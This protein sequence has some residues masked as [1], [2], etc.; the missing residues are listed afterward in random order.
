MPPVSTTVLDSY[1][2]ANNNT[3]LDGT[4]ISYAAA[5][6]TS[7]CG[8]NGNA[9]RAFSGS[10]CA[11]YRDTETFGPLAMIGMNVGVLP[12]GDTFAS[13]RA[14]LIAADPTLSAWDGY[15]LLVYQTRV[16]LARITNGGDTELINYTAVAPT[17]G[18]DY[19]AER[20]DA[21]GTWRLWRQ[22]S[23]T[24]T[25]LGSDTVDDTY[26]S[27]TNRIGIDIYDPS[28]NGRMNALYGATLVIDDG[29]E[30]NCFAM[31]AGGLEPCV[32][33]VLTSGGLFPPLS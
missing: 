18:D 12:G 30:P 15:Q 22:R 20:V 11:S 19:I 14:D 6:G 17:A 10:Y 1:D 2:R 5:F 16:V 28:S 4:G 13:L 32:S 26:E 31:T 29:P 23:A 33:R 24:W 8:I 21:S 3:T 25:Q 9:A 7:E 27:S